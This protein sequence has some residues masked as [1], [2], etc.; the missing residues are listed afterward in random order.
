MPIGFLFGDFFEVEHSKI[1]LSL[2]KGSIKLIL[3]MVTDCETQTAGG[4]VALEQLRDLYER[5]PFVRGR[6]RVELLRR[7]QRVRREV[8]DARLAR[9]RARTLTSATE[10]AS[11]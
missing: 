3:S 8:R 1:R 10:A 2:T 7:L 5:I 4:V 9:P 11:N 6:A